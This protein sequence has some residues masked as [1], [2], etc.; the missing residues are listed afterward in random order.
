MAATSSAEDGAIFA[1]IIVWCTGTPASLRAR[2]GR[3]DAENARSARRP[4]ALA[5]RR[6]RGRTQGLGTCAP[7]GLGAPTPG[8]R[9]PPEAL[10]PPPQ[11]GGSR[12]QRGKPLSVTRR[13]PL[14]GYEPADESA[15]AR[16]G[17]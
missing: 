2:R 6:V 1:M 9:S 10:G 7:G 11:G 3:T 8:G 14:P 12:Y 5:A 16:P 17:M 4:R 13:R 15:V